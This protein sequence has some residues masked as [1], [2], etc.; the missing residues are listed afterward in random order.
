MEPQEQRSSPR[1]ARRGIDG[2]SGWRLVGEQRSPPPRAM[3][4]MRSAA[5]STRRAPAPS[6]T[7]VLSLAELAAT[8]DLSF[9]LSPRRYQQEGDTSVGAPS[10]SGAWPRFV[11]E[12]D[13]QQAAA[14]RL[15]PWHPPPLPSRLPRMARNNMKR[16]GQ[17]ILSPSLLLSSNFLHCKVLHLCLVMEYEGVL[18][19]LIIMEYLDITSVANFDNH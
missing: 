14:C 4:S 18:I 17:V 19:C 5:A 12:D 2:K 9:V 7:L 15:A 8:L 13:V 1:A 11:G 3:S 10:R 6:P 16:L